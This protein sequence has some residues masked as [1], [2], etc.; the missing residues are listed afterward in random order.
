MKRVVL[1]EEPLSKRYIAPRLSLAYVFVVLCNA[2]ALALP[3][4]VL[5]STDGEFWMTSGTYREQPDVKF[6]YQFIMVLEATDA[7]GRTNEIFVSTIDSLN[8]V[9]PESYRSSNV[10][11]QKDDADLD[12][13]FDS[14]ELDASVP[15]RADERVV[16]MQAVL[17]FNYRLQK[18]VKFDMESVAYASFDSG[19]PVAEFDTKGS[20]LLSQAKPLGV[21]HYFS[22]LYAEET[23]LVDTSVTRLAVDS[24]IGSILEKYR[25]RA[26]TVDFQEKYPIKRRVG[27]SGKF[28]LR[29]KVDVPE[30]EVQYIPT[31]EEVLKDAWVKYFSVA[32]LCYLLIDRI[33]RFLFS[34]RL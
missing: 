13:V 22:E 26:V 20:L 10:Q 33:K 15:L 2:F 31:V 34:E 5:T 7:S 32:V 14:F 23:P 11:F 28:R 12:G 8:L 29:M 30:Q 4:Y 1:Y 27:E 6:L 21:R 3:F 9:R 17:F 19:L 24:N 16:S 18:R 25:E